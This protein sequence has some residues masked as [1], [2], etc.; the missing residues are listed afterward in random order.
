MAESYEKAFRNLKKKLLSERKE[1]Q[2]RLEG[3][4]KSYNKL[5]H[6]K[7]PRKEIKLPYEKNK[8]VIYENRLDLLDGKLRFL[9]PANDADI[10]YRQRQSNDFADKVSELVP[11]DLPLR[12]HGTPIY[13]AEKI[14]ASGEI[15]S[16]QDRLGVN[17]S[18]DDAVQIYITSKDSLYITSQ[19]FA[20]LTPNFNLPAGCIFVVTP[21]DLADEE[22]GRFMHMSNVYFKDDP[23]RLVAVISTPEN[24]PSLQTWLSQGGLSPSK[25]IDF[26]GFVR[27]IDRFIDSVEIPYRNISSKMNQLSSDTKPQLKTKPCLD[28]L[29]SG[30]KKRVEEQTTSL[31][32]PKKEQ[33]LGR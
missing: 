33:S 18:Q 7:D 3:V 1:V 20:D 27:D 10:A 21:K 29:I 23:D 8:V 22:A 30:A 13:G 16:F 14:I 24:I 26:D 25:A 31:N 9:R 28:A 12:F 6:S 19:G 2:K 15:V 5:L 4:Q 32:I 11:D 17:S